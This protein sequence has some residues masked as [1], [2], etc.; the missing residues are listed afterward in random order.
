[1]PGLPACSCPERDD[2]T[3]HLSIIS[4]PTDMSFRL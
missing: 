2:M 1:M 4:T 3:F